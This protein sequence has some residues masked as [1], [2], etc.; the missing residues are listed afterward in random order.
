[1]TTDSTGVLEKENK[2]HT[3]LSQLNVSLA[4]KYVTVK[5]SFD[6]QFIDHW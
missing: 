4:H 2:N 3:T 6:L 1:M 5:Y